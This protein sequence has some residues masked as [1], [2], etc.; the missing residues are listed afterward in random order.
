MIL[1]RPKK[2]KTLISDTTGYVPAE[3]LE[4]CDLPD[5]YYQGYDDCILR[6]LD[7][8]ENPHKI[9]TVAHDCWIMGWS[10]ADEDMK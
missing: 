6:G 5:S 3:K 1:N 4:V 8:Q 9:G 2:K 10:D 7:S